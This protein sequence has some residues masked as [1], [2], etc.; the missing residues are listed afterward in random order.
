MRQARIHAAG[1]GGCLEEAQSHATIDVDGKG[2]VLVF[3]HGLESSF[4]PHKWAASEHR[5]GVNL[6]KDFS[7]ATVVGIRE[8]IRRVKRPLDVVVA[9]L[10]WG[11][12]WDYE[13]SSA[14]R[15]FAHRLIGDASV[16]IVYGHSSHHVKGIEV[17]RNR[18]IMYGCGD[19]INNYE[20]IGGHKKFRPSLGILYFARVHAETGRLMNLRM[21]PMQMRRFALTRAS[22][23]DV[24]WL[25]EVLNREGEQLGTHVGHVEGR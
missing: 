4:I 14:Q 5:S 22:H 8:R 11:S 17:Y 7:D 23:A 25:R 19:I 9:S 18:L 21:T 13:I 20:G 2:R 24:V 12:N 15:D 1:A 3:A 10:H 6:L 16:D